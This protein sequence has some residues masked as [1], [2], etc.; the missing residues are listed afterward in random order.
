MELLF[1]FPADVESAE[2]DFGLNNIFEGALG[3]DGGP[4][5]KHTKDRCVYSTDLFSTSQW[6]D[7]R[8][9]K[10]SCEDIY[11]GKI[12]QISAFSISKLLL[13]RT[14]ATWGFSYGFVNISGI[15]LNKHRQQSITGS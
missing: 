2:Y 7:A 5:V 12:S 4:L 10:S 13:I 15:S 6:I 11:P 1:C 9:I 8:F 3:F 14:M